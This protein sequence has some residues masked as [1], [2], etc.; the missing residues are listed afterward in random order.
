MNMKQEQSTNLKFIDFLLHGVA[1]SKP[2]LGKIHFFPC[3]L[4]DFTPDFLWREGKYKQLGYII[5]VVVWPSTTFSCMERV[6]FLAVAPHFS[7]DSSDFWGATNDLSSSTLSDERRSIDIYLNSIHQFTDDWIKYSLQQ[8]G[9]NVISWDGI[10][11]ILM[12]DT[13]SLPPIW[14]QFNGTLTDVSENI[15][16][17]LQLLFEHPS[18]SRPRVV[19][20]VIHMKIPLFNGIEF[21]RNTEKNNTTEKK[22]STLS[23]S[24]YH[25]FPE[26]DMT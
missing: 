15:N 16:L 23:S 7:H 18:T 9:W 19:T 3:S 25:T 5:A 1:T 17:P 24:N 4:R 12:R 2:L 26:G 6:G 14:H 20:L 11:V 8:E 13:H 10:W 21:Q 22:N